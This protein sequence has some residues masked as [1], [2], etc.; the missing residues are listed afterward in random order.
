MPALRTNL[1]ALDEPTNYMSFDVLEGLEEA[2]RH[3]PGSVI[4][5]SH[6]RRFIEQ[7]Q[8]EVWEL[9]D[10]ELATGRTRLRNET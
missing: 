8:G 2:L 1:L 7:F 3:F 6:D 10:A 4:A 9:P 5:A